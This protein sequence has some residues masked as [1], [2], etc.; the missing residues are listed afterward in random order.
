MNPENPWKTLDS[1]TVY[2]NPWIRVREDRVVR[3][4]GQPGIYGVVETRGATGVL[5]LTEEME[6]WLVG[7]YRYPMEAY[8]WE[9]IEGGTDPGET[10]LA[11]IQRE[12][13]EEAGLEAERWAP[14]GGELHLSNCHSSERGWLFAA[15][16]L[17]HVPAA[18]DGTEV[19]ALRRVPFPEAVRMVMDG[20]IRDAMSIIAILTADRLLREGKTL[21]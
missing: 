9:I 7:Q 13:R 12:L 21:A 1:K 18:P 3:P 6:V 14:L 16:G 2:E 11:A 15:A 8:S 4:D 10:P 19:L 20:E 5:A 17:R